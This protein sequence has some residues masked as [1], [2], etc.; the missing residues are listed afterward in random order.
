MLLVIAIVPVIANFYYWT[1]IR[2]HF[3]RGDANPG[4]VVAVQPTLVAVATDLTKGYGS[5]PV[6]KIIKLNWKGRPGFDLHAGARLATVALY[7]AGEENAPHWANFDPRPVQ[8]LVSDP[9]DAL[10]VMNTFTEQDWQD[11]QDLLQFV[12]EPYAPGLYPIGW[13]DKA[14]LES[15]AQKRQDRRVLR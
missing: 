11:L 6:V 1:R 12:P 10:P 15:R 8:P 9:T 3:V 14:T 7:S 13:E 2:E 5:F 4:L